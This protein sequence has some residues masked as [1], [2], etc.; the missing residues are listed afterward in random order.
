MSR[1]T[2]RSVVTPG[3]EPGHFSDP[4]LL[5][6]A[7]LAGGPKHGHS[8]I[9]DIVEM[10]GTRLGPG[11]L[12]GAITRLERDGLIEPL[13]PDERRYPYKL[14]PAGLRMLKARLATLN[15]FVRAGLRRVEAR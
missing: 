15:H 7:S 11:T 1:S 9:E 12:Y 3:P 13:P 8:M 6:L 10:S 2:S 14:T 5:V 4:P